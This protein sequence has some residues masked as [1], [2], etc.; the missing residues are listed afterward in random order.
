MWGWRWLEDLTQDVRYGLRLLG[1][2]PGLRGLHSHARIGNRREHSHF[3]SRRYRDAEN[4][5]SP[6]TRRVNE[7]SVH[8]HAN[9]RRSRSESLFTNPIWEQV[10]DQQDIFSGILRGAMR[11]LIFRTAA[12]RTLS[13]QCLSAATISTRLEFNHSPDGFSLRLTTNAAAPVLLFSVTVSGRT[14]LVALNPQSEAC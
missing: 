3:Q 2:N 1:K 9:I 12:N 8:S 4:V 6:K 13:E 7:D 14:I 5:A 10:R 11:D